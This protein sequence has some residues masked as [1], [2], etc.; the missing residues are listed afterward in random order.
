M[1]AIFVAGFVLPTVICANT[2][3]DAEALFDQIRIKPFAARAAGF[4]PTGLKQPGAV[5]GLP[6]PITVE[7][8]PV[9]HVPG[10][11]VWPVLSPEPRHVPDVVSVNV[12]AIHLKAPASGQVPPHNDPEPTIW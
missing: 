9:F 5:M 10:R 3:A 8:D 11:Y 6:V 1:R 4:D 7:D 12:G 2:P